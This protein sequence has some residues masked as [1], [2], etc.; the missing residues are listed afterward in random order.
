MDIKKIG[1]IAGIVI[2]LA[3]IAFGI[4]KPAKIEYQDRIEYQEDT[5][6]IDK[7]TVQVSSL[8]NEKSIL[9]TKLQKQVDINKNINTIETYDPITGKLIKREIIDKTSVSNNTNSATTSTTTITVQD[10]TLISQI[11]TL[12][13]KIAELEEKTKITTNVGLLCLDINFM[14]MDSTLGV[15]PGLNI[16]PSA[17]ISGGPTFSVSRQLW[18]WFAN[19]RVGI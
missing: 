8:R 2:S 16:S 13:K 17:T 14:S 1:I 12:R 11:E 19:L 4:F 7:L 3:S 10:Q 18:G 9:E 6:K 15:G 5:T